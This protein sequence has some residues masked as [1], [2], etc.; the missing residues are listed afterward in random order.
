MSAGATWNRELT[1]QRGYH[2]GAEFKRKGV[3]VL[4]GPVIGGLGR[5]PLGGRNWEAY[6][7]DPYLCG[8]LGADQVSGIQAAGVTASVKRKC[9]HLM[10]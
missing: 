10:L 2:M 7:N 1:Y 5:V 9:G 3:H 4:L 6:S 8:K